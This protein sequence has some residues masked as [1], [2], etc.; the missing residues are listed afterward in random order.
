MLMRC[1]RRRSRAGLLLFTFFSCAMILPG[2]GTL[3]PRERIVTETVT[4]Y[5]D[6]VVHDTTTFEIEKEV[7]KVVTR[8]TSSHLENKYA[9]SDAVVSGGFLSHSLKS[10][11]QVIKVPY[12]VHVTDTVT[13]YKE[14]AVKTEY[15]EKELTWWQKTKINGFWWLLALAAAGWRKQLAW[16]VKKAAGLFI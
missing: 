10:K 9:E 7:E 16:L 6:R 12:E 15:V 2:C 3:R 1:H 5:R 14:S 4:E 11:P 13:I 8:D